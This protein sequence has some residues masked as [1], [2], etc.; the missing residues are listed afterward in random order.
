MLNLGIGPAAW[1]DDGDH[2]ESGSMIQPPFALQEG[3]RCLCHSPLF[4]IRNR[5]RRMAEIGRRTGLNFHEYDGFAVDGDQVN[6]AVFLTPLSVQNLVAQALEEERGFDFSAI[7][8]LLSSTACG[9]QQRREPAKHGGRALAGYASA[10]DVDVI[11][12]SRKG[13]GTI[14]RSFRFR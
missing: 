6:L 4:R 8:Q 11:S 1:P 2:I 3:E 12:R 10:M 5:F 13:T 9:I 14:A 7:A